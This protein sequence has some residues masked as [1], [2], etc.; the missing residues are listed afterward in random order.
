M[1]VPN[2]VSQPPQAVLE[3][4][5]AELENLTPETRKAA[6][7][8][9]ENPNDVSVS[10]IREIA[11]AANVKPNTF[12]RMARSVGFDGYE[13][14]REPFRD[15]IRKGGV[16]F[17]D[18][19]RWLQSL[20]KGGELSKLYADMAASAI[21]N[22]EETFAATSDGAMKL[23]A[24]AIVAARRTFVLG[25]GV[26]SS[27]ARN[28]TYL[29]DMAVDTIEAIPRYGSNAIDDLARA[30]AG[31]VL[32]A[33]TCKPYRSEVVDAVELARE[34]GLTIIAI[35][36]SPASPIVIAG[37][38]AFVIDADTPQFFPSSVATIAL[39]ETLM[40]F[41]IADADPKV[42]S[43]IERFHARRH[44]LGIYSADE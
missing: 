19:A 13:D 18:R 6:A 23:A 36:D 30:E 37:D 43:N 4:L 20:A 24:D 11:D 32:I 12:V 29:A 15:E 44:A 2:T 38:H 33:M 10:S 8:V 25:V 9:L 31:D 40:A 21:R 34:Q 26:N 42:I 7:Y 39:L 5:S 41:V 14:F 35:S 28:F 17:P 27:N 16:S 22:I 1:N 3:A